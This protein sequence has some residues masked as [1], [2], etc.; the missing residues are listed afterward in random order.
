MVLSDG[1]ANVTLAGLG[2]RQQAQTEATALGKR[3]AETGFA[4][5]WI[6]TAMQ[7]EPLAQALAH[8][9]GANYL[10]MPHVH[11]ERLASAMSHHLHT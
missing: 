3:W 6:D 4:A 8:D 10:P 5:L 9:M 7:P 1:R 11:A 2:G